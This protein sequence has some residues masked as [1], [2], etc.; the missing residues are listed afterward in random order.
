MEV[1]YCGHSPLLDFVYDLAYSVCLEI[2]IHDLPQR[3]HLLKI[4]GAH[5]RSITGITFAGS[6]RLL[7]CGVDQMVR[8]WDVQSSSE[9]HE[10]AMDEDDEPIVQVKHYIPSTIGLQ[11]LIFPVF[12]Y[13]PEDH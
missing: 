6:G 11:Y 13:R 8:L 12:Y 2:I 3:R 7:S 1:S 4:P 9:S 5:K 10:L